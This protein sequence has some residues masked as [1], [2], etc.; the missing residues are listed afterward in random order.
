[1]QPGMYLTDEIFLYR[2]VGFATGDSDVL[3]DLEDCFGLDVVRVPMAHLRDRGLRVVRPAR[4][5]GRVS[6]PS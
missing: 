5:A 3:V 1:M 2:A 6:S 4:D